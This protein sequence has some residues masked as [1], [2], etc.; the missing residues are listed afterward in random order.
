[1]ATLEG[2]IALDRPIGQLI[3][4]ARETDDAAKKAALGDCC[5]TLLRAQFDLIELITKAYPDLRNVDPK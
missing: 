3:E 1:M 2:L 5:S 4:L